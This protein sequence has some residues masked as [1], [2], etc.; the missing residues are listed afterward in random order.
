MISPLFRIFLTLQRFKC[1][2]L[3]IL[4]IGA[5]AFTG[6]YSELALAS[7]G[8]TVLPRRLD[9]ANLRPIWLINI[10]DVFRTR[11]SLLCNSSSIDV[12]QVVSELWEGYNSFYLAAT[13]NF[14][15]V[16]PTSPTNGEAGSCMYIPQ[17][18]H[19]MRQASS[20]ESFIKV[21][22]NLRNGTSGSVKSN[23]QAVDNEGLFALENFFW[24][25]TDGVALELGALDGSYLS[26][27]IAPSQTAEFG[28]VGWNRILIEANPYYRRSMKK[29]ASEAYTVS[30]RG[31]N[32]NEFSLTSYRLV[33]KTSELHMIEDLKKILLPL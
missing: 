20:N 18:G 15:V 23:Q 32:L 4:I 12:G 16:T 5:E 13:L 26:S 19:R 8:T 24:G 33:L 30:L 27:F 3:L 1:L 25:M 11:L 6:D 9:T 7:G 17:L 10:P 21:C 31:L 29:N 28:E 14:T 2:L 22:D